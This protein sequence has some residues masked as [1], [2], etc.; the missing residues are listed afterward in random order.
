LYV[1]GG[2]AFVN[3]RDTLTQGTLGRSVSKTASGWA[4]GGGLET[5][6]DARWSA[7]LES[8]YMNVGT[9]ETSGLAGIRT[10]FK[11]R[12]QIIRAGLNYSFGGG[13]DH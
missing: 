5:A 3:V 12:F 11:N 1:T 8:L 4:F 2:A 7:R 13:A 6:L 9:E 10:E